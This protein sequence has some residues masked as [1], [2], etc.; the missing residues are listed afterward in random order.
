MAAGLVLLCVALMS[1]ASGELLQNG[2]FESL[3]NWGCY[4]F[5]CKLTTDRHSGQHAVEVS[6]RQHWYQGPSQMITVTQ[7]TEY[8]VTGY[9][10]LLTDHGDNGQRVELEVDM[11]LGDDTHLYQSAAAHNGVRVAD[12]WVYLSGTFAVPSQRP[13]P[14]VHF[15]VD[16]A[17]VTQIGQLGVSWQNY[18]QSVIEQHRKSDIHIDVTTASGI[19][20][21]DVQIHV[22]Q[23]KKSFPFGVAIGAERYNDPNN[24]AYRDF[25]HT[26]FNWAVIDNALKWRPGQYHYQPAIDALHGLKRNGMKIRAHNIVW[27]VPDFIQPWVK[28]LSGD[29]LRSVVKEHI[30]MDMNVTRGLT[31]EVFLL[32]AVLVLCL[33][34][35]LHRKRGQ[36]HPISWLQQLNTSVRG[37]HVRQRHQAAIDKARQC[38][39]PQTLRRRASYVVML[40]ACLLLGNHLHLIPLY[41]IPPTGNANVFVPNTTDCR[42]HLPVHIPMKGRSEICTYDPKEDRR[43]RKIHK[44]G[45]PTFEVDILS[46]LDIMSSDVMMN[47]RPVASFV[48]LGCYIGTFT[49]TVAS[50]GYKVLAVDAMNSSLQLLATSL[51]WAS[52]TDRVTILHNAISDRR[53]DVV[54]QVDLGNRG[55][56]WIEHNASASD[57]S[58]SK[59]RKVNTQP[60]VKAICMDDLVP[61]VPTRRVLLKMDVEGSEWLALRCADRFFAEVDVPFIHMNFA[62]Y[63]T[64][65]KHR[66]RKISRYLSKR[67]YSAHNPRKPGLPL[68][69]EPPNFW[70][71]NVLWVKTQ[72]TD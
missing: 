11:L 50:M 41:L 47:G 22:V 33:V 2:G 23:T 29:E 19:N 4:S 31:L 18:S 39:C 54:V 27:S 62:S 37:Y 30:E 57:I 61:Y 26:H 9:I 70:I 67:G 38:F 12:G 66:G 40:V 36:T 51:R 49:I 5:T 43:S 64:K 1:T 7:D 65:H 63:N 46:I 10:K 53:K 6:G 72:E 68:M 71:G 25:V 42:F 34:I 16:D 58:I 55:A 60:V 14:E 59:A 20:K 3:Q 52:L 56:S 15:V 44:S 13:D 8:N 32:V 69:Y 35:N 28:Q 48:D 17:S 24:Q 21:A 45:H